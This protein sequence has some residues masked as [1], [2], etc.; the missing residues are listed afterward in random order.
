[1]PAVTARVVF[2]VNGTT[3]VMTEIVCE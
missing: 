1:V 2:E 3:S